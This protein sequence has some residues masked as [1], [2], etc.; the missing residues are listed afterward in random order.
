M[1]YNIKIDGTGSLDQIA[2][3]L[4]NLS[5]DLSEIEA[6]NPEWDG[7]GNF[8]DPMLNISVTP[9]KSFLWVDKSGSG[10]PSIPHTYESLLLVNDKEEPSNL[11]YDGLVLS[12]WVEEA[13]VGEEWENAAEK[14]IRV[15]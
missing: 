12:E 7:K 4:R 2:S 11:N 14:Y 6:K 5:I 15:E 1:Q 13:E 9:T 10:R 8:K 3:S